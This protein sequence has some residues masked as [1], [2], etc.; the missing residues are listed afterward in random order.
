MKLLNRVC[1]PIR[2]PKLR[3]LA[4]WGN[5]MTQSEESYPAFPVAILSSLSFLD[6]KMIDPEERAQAIEK[7]EIKGFANF[8]VNKYS[9]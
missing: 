2:F 8:L 5:E 6:F 3:S 9:F 4:I 7:Y 1:R